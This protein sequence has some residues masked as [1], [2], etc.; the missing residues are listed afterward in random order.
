MSTPTT[1]RGNSTEVG[2]KRLGTEHRR[3]LINAS[4]PSGSDQKV[5]SDPFNNPKGPRKWLR[6]D[7]IQRGL[8]RFE[9]IFTKLTD[10]YS[11]TYRI[12]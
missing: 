8:S 5:L 10:P 9:G 7:R 12:P 11:V 3:L 4:T 1:R 6:F 2:D